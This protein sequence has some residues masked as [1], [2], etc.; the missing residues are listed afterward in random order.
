MVADIGELAAI[1]VAEIV[2]VGAAPADLAGRRLRQ[3][4]ECAQQRGLAAAVGADDM[5]Q[6]A[7]PE[8]EREIL[9]QRAVTAY[10][11]Q[12]GNVEQVVFAFSRVWCPGPELNRRPVA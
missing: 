5:Q 11:R 4:A 7:G 3:P 10:A 9:K 8:P 2:D 12:I 1:I 6:F